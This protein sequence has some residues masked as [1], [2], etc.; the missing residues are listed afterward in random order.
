M[1]KPDKC[2]NSQ[3]EYQPLPTARHIRLLRSVPTEATK[4]GGYYQIVLGNLDDGPKYNALSYTWGDPFARDGVEGEPWLDHKSQLIL[5]DGSSLTIGRNL[6]R[7]LSCFQELSLFGDVWIDAI[8]IHQRDTQERNAQVGMMGDIYAGA[9]K[10]IVWLGDTDWNSDVAQVFIEKFLPKVERLKEREIGADTN[11]SYVFNDPRFYDRLEEPEPPEEVFDGL[12]LF[13]ERSW[14]RRAWT[15]QEVLLAREIQMY[16]GSTEIEWNNLEK[17]LSFLETSEWDMRL[18]RFKHTEKIQ[19]VPGR[20]IRTTMWFRDHIAQGGPEEQSYQTYLEQISSGDTP[21]DRMMGYL[22]HLLYSMRCRRATDS[23]DFLNALYG[24][25]ARISKDIGV[26]NPLV[27]PDYDKDVVPVFAENCKAILTNSKSLLLLSNVED[28]A[29]DTSALPSWCPDW[30]RDW[31]LGLP[32]STASAA[33]FDASHGLAPRL[34]DSS[35]LERLTLEALHFDDISALGENDYE[36]GAGGVA[37][38]RTASIIMK[39]PREYPIT[40]QDRAEVLWR[41]LVADTVQSQ[42]PAAMRISDSFR[43]HMLM[44]N[45]MAV[46]NAERRS[47]NGKADS[48]I[49]KPLADLASSSEYASRVLP[50]VAQIMERK[51]AYTN[52]QALKDAPSLSEEQTADLK[53]SIVSMLAQEEKARIFAR[54]LGGFFISKRIATTIDGFMGAAPLSA[55]EG[56]G[57]YILPGAKVP[58]VLRGRGDGTYRLVG[59]VYVH[60]IMQGEAFAERQMIAQKVTLS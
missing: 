2:V 33:L 27:A 50:S 22:D 7:A 34:C 36:L 57:V 38:T 31:H 39:I 40:S 37:F 47:A 51:D 1:E 43:E 6:F 8:C 5:G 9:D 52:I 18:S 13:L 10:V 46:F 17:L 58:F 54:S 32:R 19:Q 41:T 53:R 55:R 4:P 59:E 49:L 24:L 14:F 20:M 29:D 23:R 16:C 21:N 11:F 30:T 45:A 56:D 44:H 60:G 15:F 25:T 12:A 26:T 3:Y 28:R 42:R 48:D 35:A